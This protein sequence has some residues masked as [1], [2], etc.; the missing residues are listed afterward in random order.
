[1]AI[2]ELAVLRPR[3]E[4]SMSLY[5][6]FTER[7]RKVMY[8]ARDEAKRYD[9]A[10]IGTGH[11]LL[12][13][14]KEGNGVAP[15]V[16]K[17]LG[18]DYHAIEAE[19]QELSLKE[20][21]LNAAAERSTPSATKKVIAYALQEFRD[22]RCEYVDVEHLLLGLLRETD[23]VG[24]QVLMNHGLKPEIVRQQVLDLLKRGAF[25]EVPP[26]PGRGD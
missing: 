17:T 2:D 23:S 9:H 24:V 7:A 6:L 18:F 26:E 10:F 20:T 11:L 3:S 19:I 14:V 8:L 12:G 1:M 13:I 25:N 5:E 15:N 16:L 21:Q 4:K 22:L